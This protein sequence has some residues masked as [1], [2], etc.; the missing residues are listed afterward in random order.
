MS[1]IRNIV[2]YKKIRE[3]TF[4]TAIDPADY[5][6][7]K[8]TNVVPRGARFTSYLPSSDTFTKGYVIASIEPKTSCLEH[9]GE[10]IYEVKND[11]PI[12]I[13]LF[14]GVVDSPSELL[15]K[16]E[17]LKKKFSKNIDNFKSACLSQKYVMGEKD[18]V[19]HLFHIDDQEG[20][21][22]I[23]DYG[24]LNDIYKKLSEAQQ[25]IANDA[26]TKKG[27]A[28][29]LETFRRFENV[30]TMINNRN[31]TPDYKKM[32]YI[33]R[34]AQIKP[35]QRKITNWHDCYLDISPQG[36]KEES[37]LL[38]LSSLK[39]IQSGMN[40]LHKS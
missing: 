17:K 32:D 34:L 37:R 9:K 18:D 16:Y 23:S 30:L 7:W 8:F 4:Y 39:W 13:N 12:D 15:D 14:I 2:E 33:F 35:V 29:E 22:V 10:G 38:A 11:T 3:G 27:R 24:S 1:W 40:I 19:P 28:F 31:L 25:K 36:S 20:K 6:E 5:Y 21:V 26:V